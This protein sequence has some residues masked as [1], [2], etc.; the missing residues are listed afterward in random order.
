MI[1]IQDFKYLSSVDLEFDELGQ[2]RELKEK[3]MW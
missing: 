2:H 3:L 1:P